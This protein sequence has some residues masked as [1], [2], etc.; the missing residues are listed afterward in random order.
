MKGECTAAED[1]KLT[2]HV[3]KDGRMD[4]CAWCVTRE[5]AFRI[6]PTH[7]GSESGVSWLSCVPRKEHELWKLIAVP[8]SGW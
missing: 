6:S 7:R 2:I 1:L 8:H 5:P 4:V 3:Q